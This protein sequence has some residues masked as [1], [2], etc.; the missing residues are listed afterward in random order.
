MTFFS[1][2]NYPTARNNHNNNLSGLKEHFSGLI[3]FLII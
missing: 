1:E 3:Y 2:G